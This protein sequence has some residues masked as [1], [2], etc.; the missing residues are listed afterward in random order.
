MNNTQPIPT[1]HQILDSAIILDESLQK[2]IR[3]VRTLRILD[4][5]GNPNSAIYTAAAALSQT[6]MAAITQTQTL[7]NLLTLGDKIAPR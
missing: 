6:I 3:Q 1:L 2:S 4:T 5:P 7:K